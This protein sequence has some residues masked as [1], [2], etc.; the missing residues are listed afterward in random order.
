VITTAFTYSERKAGTRTTAQPGVPLFL[1]E[2]IE[3]VLEFSEPLSEV[4]R[5]RI[6]ECGFEGVTASSGI[7]RFTNF[8]GTTNIAGVPITVVSTKLGDGGVSRL[9]E[10]VSSL[11][12]NL[13]YGWRSKTKY[14]AV[15]SGATTAV[16]PYHQLQ[17]LRTVMLQRPVGQRLQ[18]YVQI[19]E[20][21]PTRR[22]VQDRPLV[23][24]ERSRK[25]DGKAVLEIFKQP[26]R[27][28]ALEVGSALF[29]HPLAKR[30][31]FGSP[32]TRHFPL[33]VSQAVRKLSYDTAEN[34]FI[35]YLLEAS[36]ALAYKFLDNKLLHVQV[37]NDC[38][39]I[40]SVLEN[41]IEAPFLSEVQS[42]FTIQTPSQ[43]LTKSSGY[44]ELW[45]LW[46]LF[47]SHM[48]LPSSSQVVQQFLEGRNVADLYEYWVF[49]KVLD[50]SVKVLGIDSSSVGVT[51]RR[52]DLGEVMERG[53][54]IALTEKVSVSFNRQFSRTKG[55]AYSTPL[56]PDVVLKIG[57]DMYVFD[58]KYRLRWR[59]IIDDTTEEQDENEESATYLRADLYK[60]HAY[61]DAL[62]QVRAAFVVYPG[63]Q[64]TFFEL[65]DGL[66]KNVDEVENWDGVGAIPARPGGASEV[67]L[68]EKV[69]LKLLCPLHST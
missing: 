26:G 19:V 64:Y 3:Y 51:V 61:R 27:L 50:A 44:K 56:R 36:L 29:D 41:L 18:D 37:R 69:I 8:V 12:S 58:A 14:H 45:E 66:R 42:N 1:Q 5:N 2:N 23:P 67:E 6:S 38:R 32:P 34:Q 4:D 21:N 62:L 49:L 53:L 35:K 47:R 22:F 15:E 40:V 57:D 43:T 52:T 17:F 25:L 30:L 13:V 60:M 55:D 24:I 7:L 16:I 10:E 46:T 28:A 9:L 31:E 20:E 59:E 68:L 39:M 54:S 65:G 33:V 63:T 48:S 11:S